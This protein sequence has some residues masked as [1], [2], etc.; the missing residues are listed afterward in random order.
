VSEVQKFG[1]A[2]IFGLT[3]DFPNSVSTPIAAPLTLIAGKDAKQV[4]VYAKV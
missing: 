3:L 4:T 1:A 2:E